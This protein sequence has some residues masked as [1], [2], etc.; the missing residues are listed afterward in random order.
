MELEKFGVKE[1]DVVEMKTT[2]GGFVDFLYEF[3]TGRSL[4]SDARYVVN[5]AAEAY[6]QVIQ[7]G[8]TTASTMPFK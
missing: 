2:D 3:F 4:A 1:M 6:A 5:Q 8:G 7:E